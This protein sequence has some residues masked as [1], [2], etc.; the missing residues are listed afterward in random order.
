MAKD[1]SELGDKAEKKAKKEKKEKEKHVEKN[2]VSKHKKEKKLKQVPPPQ[3]SRG[4]HQTIADLSRPIAPFQAWCLPRTKLAMSKC[5]A[6]QKTSPKR[7][8]G[9]WKRNPN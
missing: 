4:M 8:H 3:S 2:G 1:K 9:Q 7:P 5:Q 6:Y